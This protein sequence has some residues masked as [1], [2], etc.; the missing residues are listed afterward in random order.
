M[1]CVTLIQ[2]QIIKETDA[3]QNLHQQ[4]WMAMQVETEEPSQ[5]TN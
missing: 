5:V 4:G 2:K 3:M 1:I